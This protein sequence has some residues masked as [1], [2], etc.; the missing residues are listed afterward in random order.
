MGVK[1]SILIIS[2]FKGHKIANFVAR[3]LLYVAKKGEITPWIRVLG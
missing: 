3:I 2:E 1:L